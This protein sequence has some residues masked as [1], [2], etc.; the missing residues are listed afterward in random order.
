V[1]LPCL[2]FLLFLQK[3]AS[4][5]GVMMMA[6]KKNINGINPPKKASFLASK[7]AC[8]AWRSDNTL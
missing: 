5:L 2:F 1:L 6:K 8:L 3:K 4:F 7:F